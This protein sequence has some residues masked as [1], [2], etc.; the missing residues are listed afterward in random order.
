MPG[1]P[2]LADRGLLTLANLELHRQNVSK[3]FDKS[4]EVGV[5]GAAW[6]HSDQRRDEEHLEIHIRQRVL[7]I[8]MHTT[9]P[10]G[11]TSQHW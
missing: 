2:L 8:K 5:E 9:I 3:L 4:A 11:C 6:P 1:A 10:V 7:S